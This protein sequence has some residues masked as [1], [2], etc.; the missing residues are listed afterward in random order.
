MG[1]TAE[2][3]WKYKSNLLHQTDVLIRDA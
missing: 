3:F 1:K 2:N